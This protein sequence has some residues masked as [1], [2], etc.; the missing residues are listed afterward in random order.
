M[1]LSNCILAHIHCLHMYDVQVFIIL[2]F[3]FY[4]ASYW[5][6]GPLY[7]P[8]PVQSVFLLKGKLFLPVLLAF[9]ESDIF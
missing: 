6:D 5:Q 1:M 7:E 8:G 4:S 3:L 9:M 2:F